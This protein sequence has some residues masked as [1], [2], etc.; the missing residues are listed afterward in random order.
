MKLALDG[1]PRS[2]NVRLASNAGDSHIKHLLIIYHDEFQI[3][4][5]KCC[6]VKHFDD[7]YECIYR[8]YEHRYAWIR[9][10]MRNSAANRMHACDR[11][12]SRL[13]LYSRCG[14][15][16]VPMAL[17]FDVSVRMMMPAS[18]RSA[19]ARFVLRPCIIYRCI[20]MSNE[21]CHEGNRASMWNRTARIMALDAIRRFRANASRNDDW[22]MI[23]A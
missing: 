4:M 19:H 16:A 11:D 23:G 13:M 15:V 14:R 5:L 8:G 20:V 22:A 9:V 2:H 6:R 3:S 21:P 18:L 10:T 17:I 1:V 7:V 12:L